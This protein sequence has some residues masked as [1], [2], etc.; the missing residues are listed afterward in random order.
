MVINNT[1][2]LKKQEIAKKSLNNYFTNIGL[3]EQGDFEKY[4]P[5]C[6]TV[7]IYGPLTNE[8]LR[9][10]FYYLRTNKSPRYE[11]Y[12]SMQ[13]IMFLTLY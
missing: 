2:V 6:I 11:I 1:K 7:M 9:N 10:A 12:L 5:N 8:E 3:K 4:L 13:L